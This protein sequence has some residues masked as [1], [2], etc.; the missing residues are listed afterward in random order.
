MTSCRQS[1]LTFGAA[2][3]PPV[4]P[5]ITRLGF[6]LADHGH[7]AQPQ[8]CWVGGLSRANGGREQPSETRCL[9]ATKDATTA[10]DHDI[11]AG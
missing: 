5:D 6:Q 4:R 2:G 9:L 11:E 1:A 7:Q 3:Q 10:A 8:G